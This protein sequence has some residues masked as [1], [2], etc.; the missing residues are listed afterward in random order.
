MGP[1]DRFFVA[2]VA[3]K[4]WVEEDLKEARAKGLIKK[5]FDVTRLLEKIRK[6]IDEE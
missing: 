3:L 2:S 5:P 1:K 4:E 6:V